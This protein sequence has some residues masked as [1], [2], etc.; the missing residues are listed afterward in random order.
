MSLSHDVT[1]KTEHVCDSERAKVGYKGTLAGGGERENHHWGVD[2]HIQFNTAGT[3][4]L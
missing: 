4:L 1:G 2:S 3:L